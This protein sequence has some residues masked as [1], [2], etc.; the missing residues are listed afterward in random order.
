MFFCLKYLLFKIILGYLANLIKLQ[1]MML[2]LICSTVAK[3][4]LNLPMEKI[5]I[6]VNSLFVCYFLSPTCLNQINNDSTS[7]ALPGR[8]P[9]SQSI[10]R[11]L[12]LLYFPFNFQFFFPCLTSTKAFCT[13]TA[14]LAFRKLTF[15]AFFTHQKLSLHICVCP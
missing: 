12:C 11:F 1:M 5:F 13:A 3:N 4:L 2:T 10:F 9:R 14:S 15:N 7:T 8:Q 6:I